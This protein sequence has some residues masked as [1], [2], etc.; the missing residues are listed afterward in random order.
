MLFANNCWQTLEE[1]STLWSIAFKPKNNSPIVH[2]S[3]HDEQNGAPERRSQ[4]NLKLRISR[5][6]PV[7]FNVELNR[8]AEEFV[9]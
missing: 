6:R 7:T 8:S 5:R 4:A 9:G 3:D 1:R 2:A